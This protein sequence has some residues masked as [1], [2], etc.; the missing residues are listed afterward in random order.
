VFWDEK[1]A[2]THHLQEDTKRGA[3]VIN[4]VVQGANDAREEAR[5]GPVPAALLHDKILGRTD[6]APAT[7]KYKGGDGVT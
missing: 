7:P 5:L 2:T 4:D 1:K 3:L 6:V